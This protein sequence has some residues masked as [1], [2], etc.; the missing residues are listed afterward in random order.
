M[1]KERILTQEELR[2]AYP[3]VMKVAEVLYNVDNVYYG[4]KIPFNEIS[5]I[6]LE[7]YMRRARAAIDATLE[8]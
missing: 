6:R 1:M 7:M 8:A 3:T 2:Q 5:H 4:F